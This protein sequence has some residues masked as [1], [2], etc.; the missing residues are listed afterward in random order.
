M[1]GQ[2]KLSTAPMWSVVERH[3][4]EL[5][6]LLELRAEALVSPDYDLDD[7]VG[8]FDRRIYEQLWGLYLASPEALARIVDPAL[9][10]IELSEALG[11]A[12][13]LTISS[14]ASHQACERA[15]ELLE[16]ELALDGDWNLEQLASFRR[17]VIQGIA[18]TER[19]G[20]DAWLL[21]W[22]NFELGGG[23]GANV[24]RVT[25]LLEV[26][27]AR[28]LAPQH[29]CELLAR[30]EPGLLRAAALTA[31]YD[32]DPRSAQALAWLAGH[33]EPKV[34][35][36]A[37]ESGLVRGVPEAWQAT[38]DWA[39]QGAGEGRP[40]ELRARALTWVG[41]LGD[42]DLH[43]RLLAD[44]PERASERAAQLWAASFSGRSEAIE[45]G[46]SSIDDPELGPLAGELIT[47]IAG[48]DVDDE[49]LWLP[50]EADEDNGLPPLQ[51]DELDG[52]LSADPRDFLPVPRPEAFHAWW[53]R[54]RPRFEAAP[55]WL[56]GAPWTLAGVL[57]QLRRGPLRRRHV[58]ALELA[59]RSGGQHQL[60]A[61][62]WA[63]KQ[64]A[65]L[66]AAHAAT[67]PRS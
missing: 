33:P 21:G 27:A 50:R 32:R 53:A 10:S 16:P 55:R 60:Q 23:R 30:D 4:S 46:L 42:A 14:L 17:G 59:V 35:A 22:I 28:S 52:D 48:L 45:L 31:R 54:A 19:E 67:D 61:S 13:S 11:S 18:L 43:A 64:L 41:L 65:Q 5:E 29:L 47:A 51:L 25:G 3:F 38:I 6:L 34:V 37:L 24:R 39:F 44:V 8:G 26:L 36:A 12:A 63:T 9:D 58:L 1:P 62:S 66:A 2:P 7:L 49:T 15:L 20:L 56:A 40:A 57:D